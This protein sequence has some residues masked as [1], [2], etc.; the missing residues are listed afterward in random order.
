[1][2]IRFL[3]AL[4][5]SILTISIFAAIGALAYFTFDGLMGILIGTLFA[6]LACL[7]GYQVFKTVM[8]VGVLKFI[9]TNYS[10]SDLDNLKATPSDSYQILEAKNLITAFENE[11]ANFHGGTLKIW[12]DWQGRDLQK[13]NKIEELKYNEN[14]HVL[15]IYFKNGN[16]LNLTKPN[17]IVSG[18]TYLKIVRAESIEWRWASILDDFKFS[19]YTRKEQDIEL[20]SNVKWSSFRTFLSVGEPALV[21]TYKSDE[22]ENND[23][24]LNSMLDETYS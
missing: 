2:I 7:S 4:W 10:S 1:M 13:N 23:I 9:S 15:S 11:P 20:D 6:I 24:I 22:S 16:I 19:K 8:Q 12:G 21:I 5:H 3:I 18:K 17:L 14:C